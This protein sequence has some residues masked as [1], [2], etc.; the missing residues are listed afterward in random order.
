MVSNASD[1]GSILDK[2]RYN[3]TLNDI[4]G[5]DTIIL[6]SSHIF[7]KCDAEILRLIL[8]VVDKAE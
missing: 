4:P 5:I 6:D 8:D 1:I 7:V 2:S 3:K